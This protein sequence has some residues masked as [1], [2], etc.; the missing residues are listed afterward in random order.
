[1]SGMPE[2][3]EQ[4]RNRWRSIL[5][6]F[7]IETK[8]LGGRHGPCPI[9]DGTDRFRFDDKEGKGTF[10]CNQCGAGDGVRLLMLKTGRGFADVVRDIR[11]RLGETSTAPAPKGRHPEALKRAAQDLW[12]SAAPLCSGDFAAGYLTG[13]RI[14]GPYPTALRFCGSARIVGHPTRSTLPAMLALVCEPGG[15]PVNVHRTYLDGPTKAAI[16]APRKMMAGEVPEGS[17]IR[18]ARHDGVLG[19]AE[20]IETAMR[21]SRRFGTPC[22]SLIDAEKLK[23]FVIPPGLRELHIFGDNDRNYV[24]QAAAFELG[25]RAATMRGGPCVVRVHIPP[26]SGTDWADDQPCDVA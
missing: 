1:M 4:C 6:L 8:F 18:L 22:W 3:A 15:K 7:G 10:Y 19:V 13:R 16:D 5:P 9:C 26:A 20:G 2:I 21:A 24:G 12:A 14:P 25:R 11:E 17:A 23:R